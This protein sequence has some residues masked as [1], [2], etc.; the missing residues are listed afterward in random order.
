MSI[1]SKD[2]IFLD[3]DLNSKEEVFEFIAQKAVSLGIGTEKNKI[4]DDLLARENEISTGLESNFAIPHAQSSAIEKPALLFLSLKSGLD[5]Q[6]FDDSKAK[7]IFCILLPK[8]GFEQNQVEIL[9]KVARI[10]LNPEIKEIILSKDE[11]VIFNSISKFIFEKD[12]VENQET[13]SQKIPINAKKVVG[14][15]SCTVGIAHTYLAAEKLEMGLKQNGYIPK[16]ETR[17]SVG[18]KNVLTKEDIDQAEFVIVASDLEIDSS[19]FDQKKVYFTSTKAAIHETESVIQKAKKAPILHNKQKKQTQ[20]QENRTSVVKHII[21][22][23]SYMIPYVVFGGIMI[24]LSLGIG[25]AIYG[26]AN[27]AP[28]G[29]FLWWMLQIGVIAFKLMI[30]V[31]GGYI[32]YSIAGRAA[33]APGFIVATVGNTNDLF[34]GIGGI[35]VQTPMGFIGAVIFGIL[36][37][38]SVK[39]INSLKIQKSLSAILPIFVIPIGVSLF[40]SLIVIFLIGAPIGWVLDKLIAGLKHVFENKDGIGVGVAFLLGLLLGGMAGFDMGGPVN[41]VAFLTSTALVSTQVYEPMGMMAAAIPVAPIGMG[42]TTLIWRRKF[43]KEEKSLGLSAIIMGFIGISEGAIPFAI[44]DPKRVISAN[45][46]GSAVAGGLAGVLAVTNQAGH[47]GPIVAILGA[48]GS[49]KHGIGLGIAFF[50]LSVIVGSFTTALIYGFW[51]D[52]NFNIFSNLA[53]KNHKK[54]VK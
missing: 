53:R 51:K 3:Q 23:I 45:V 44:A 20:N 4:F 16:I 17:G 12:Q 6:N 38:Y 27:E 26:N 35:S 41:K 8:S 33:L 1:F 47:G 29:D 32:A 43:T 11:N 40:W 19:I 13:N 14:I 5:W 30:G 21:T 46:I 52:R 25:K 49:I 31:L 42:I 50:F 37:G 9:A 18:P 28:K 34:Y 24:A 15:T 54:G 22:G 2:F 39:F 48:V 7:F 10:I 36:V